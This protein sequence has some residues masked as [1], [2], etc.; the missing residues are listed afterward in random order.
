MTD[1]KDIGYILGI[2]ISRDRNTET[3]QFIQEKYKTT[4]LNKF[5]MINFIQSQH[6]SLQACVILELAMLLL[7]LHKLNLCRQFHKLNIW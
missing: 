2:Q 3:L 6:H 5:N 4:F 7:Y 1:N